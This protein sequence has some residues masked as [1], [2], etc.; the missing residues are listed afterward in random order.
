MP[1]PAGW[2]SPGACRAAA[3]G[4]GRHCAQAARAA[5]CP[6]IRPRGGSGRKRLGSPFFSRKHPPGIPASTP[7]PADP[8][9]GP[10][11]RLSL[12]VPSSMVCEEQG[13]Q[14]I[15]CPALHRRAD[16]TPLHLGTHAHKLGV[17]QRPG[18][19]HVFVAVKRGVP[20]GKALAGSAIPSAGRRR[21]RGGRNPEGSRKCRGRSLPGESSGG[22]GEA[23]SL[24][25]GRHRR[26][27]AAEHGPP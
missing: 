10:P 18:S 11:H 8:I 9:P 14:D 3:E 27:C 2:T 13:T 20:A 26:P 24:Q 12:A 16:P 17:H 21:C 4:L 15:A 1:A 25:R 19:A 6:G 7:R 22:S 5:Q 23:L